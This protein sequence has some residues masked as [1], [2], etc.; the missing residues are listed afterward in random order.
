MRPVDQ[1][2]RFLIVTEGSS[3]ATIIRHALNLLKLHVADF[4]GSCPGRWC[5]SVA[6]YAAP[7]G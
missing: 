6:L 5:K 2:N 3:D 1:E 7:G 4:F